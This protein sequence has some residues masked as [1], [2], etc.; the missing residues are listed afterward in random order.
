[1]SER[2]PALLTR[3]EAAEYLG[4]GITALNS[5]RASGELKSVRIRE[6]TIRYRKSD[7]DKLVESLPEESG[8]FKGKVTV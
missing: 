1:M 3:E 4:I 7:L 2:W 6:A 5:L 8:K